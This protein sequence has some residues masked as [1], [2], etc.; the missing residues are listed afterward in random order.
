M[1]INKVIA[2]DSQTKQY[3]TYLFGD[4]YVGR[5]VLFSEALCA[6]LDFCFLG[7]NLSPMCV[8]VH[9]S[10]G[11]EDFAFSKVHTADGNDFS[12]LRKNDG[13][14]WKTIARDDDALV[15]LKKR[16]ASDGIPVCVTKDSVE[17]FRGNLSDFLQTKADACGALAQTIK[18][19]SLQ[20]A[21]A[22][23]K[24]R[25]FSLTDGQ[26]PIVAL[27][28]ITKTAKRVGEI[29]PRLCKSNAEE[30]NVGHLADDAVS[31]I[32]KLQKQ[33]A[34]LRDLLP[35][36]EVK[37]RQLTE[38]QTL[39]EQ[40]IAASR[41]DE[42]LRK[43]LDETNGKL[44]I[45][46]TALAKT[47]KALRANE[48]EQKICENDIRNSAQLIAELSA[49]E[50]FLL[51]QTENFANVSLAEMRVI[52]AAA[53]AQV[54]AD[55]LKKLQT[56]QTS[57]ADSKAIDALLKAASTKA[58]F[59]SGKQISLSAENG[60]LAVKIGG[61]ESHFDDLPFAVRSTVFIALALSRVSAEPKCLAFAPDVTA[62]SQKLTEL[63][64]KEKARCPLA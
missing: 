9:F 27:E 47:E 53:Q 20:K 32:A 51:E 49:A 24:V 52:A 48:H 57:L 4:V 50:K 35:L 28:Q 30:D 17:N 44:R 10:D 46:A 58:S 37:R 60:V 31:R 8:E 26:N 25:Q 56:L 62:D 19:L 1:R 7:G 64:S 34:K 63:L 14:G 22:E 40:A 16:C 5:Q 21:A 41:K 39:C 29:V 3:E 6:Y 59:L 42:S 43:R 2:T 33:N 23:N 13:V 36:I 54:L 55:T 15:L 61:A 12:M 11:D 45:V 18:E 38:E